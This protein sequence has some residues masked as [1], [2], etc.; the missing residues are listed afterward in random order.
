MKSQAIL[1]VNGVYRPSWL[2]PIAVAVANEPMVR[3]WGEP[4]R[5]SAAGASPGWPGEHRL[6]AADPR[7]QIARKRTPLARLEPARVRY[8]SHSR[9][10][11]RS[12]PHPPRTGPRIR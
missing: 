1:G 9:F 5:Y 10:A 8:G 12:W 6:R 4:A 7:G 11:R 3:T 2:L